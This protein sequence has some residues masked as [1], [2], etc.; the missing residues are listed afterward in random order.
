MQQ[1]VIVAALFYLYYKIKR[2]WQFSGKIQ[3]WRGA[4]QLQDIYYL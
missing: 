1:N 2:T 3:R 4:I